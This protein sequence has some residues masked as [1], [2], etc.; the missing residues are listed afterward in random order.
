MRVAAL[1][2]SPGVLA[3][4]RRYRDIA[5]AAHD[6]RN[7][8]VHGDSKRQAEILRRVQKLGVNRLSDLTGRIEGYARRTIRVALDDPAVLHPTSLDD[9]LLGGV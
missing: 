3:E 6:M 2:A 8:I 1:L 4:K 5:K 9:R 7:A